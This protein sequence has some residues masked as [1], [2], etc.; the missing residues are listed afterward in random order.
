MFILDMKLILNMIIKVHIIPGFNRHCL[1]LENSYS[2]GILL[3]SGRFI[4]SPVVLPEPLD[5]RAFVL[6]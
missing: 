5:C 4:T 6:T 2:K 1:L 3:F